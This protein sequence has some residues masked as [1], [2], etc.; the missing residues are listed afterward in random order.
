M[1]REEITKGRQGIKREGGDTD[2]HPGSSKDLK[3]PGMVGHQLAQQ[4]AHKP[5]LWRGQGCGAPWEWVRG[6]LWAEVGRLPGGW[7]EG[8]P[9]F[10]QPGLP[11]SRVSLCWQRLSR[12]LPPAPG[13]RGLSPD[14]F[15][16]SVPS[17]QPNIWPHQTRPVVLKVRGKENRPGIRKCFPRQSVF[18]ESWVLPGD[19]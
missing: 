19:S 1:F 16:F 5:Y 17:L 6:S 13:S 10:L 15:L 18:G 9:S 12:V 8:L 3:F 4:V 2:R 14:L 7:G 11:L